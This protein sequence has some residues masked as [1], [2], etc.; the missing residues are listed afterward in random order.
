MNQPSKHFLSLLILFFNLARLSG[1]YTLADA[2]MA[3]VRKDYNQ[4]LKIC[5]FLK[6][7]GQQSPAIDTRFGIIFSSLSEHD[8][9]LYHLKLAEAGGEK[10]I[11]SGLLIAECYEALGK[12]DSASAKYEEVIYTDRTNLFPVISF[13]KMLITNRLYSDAVKWCQLLVDSVPDNFVFRKNL[14]GCFL[15]M[16]M[17]MEALYHLNEAW[18]LNNN[19]ISLLPA[20]TTG[21]LRAKIPESG[22]PVLREATA[23]HSDNPVVHKCS[24]NLYFASES[25]D[26]AAI[27]YKKAY[28]YGDTSLHIIRQLGLCYYAGN[29]FTEAVPF[30]LKSYESDTLDFEAVQY[31]ALSLSN[32]SRQKE[33]INYFRK[34]INILLPDSALLGSLH[35]EIG[36]ASGDINNYSVAI[37][38]YKEASKFLPDEIDY[39][40]ELARLYDA[41]KN[42]QEA[43]NHYERY[44]ANQDRL[45]KEIA[46][47]RNLNPAII[48]LGP[49]HTYARE[50]IEKMREELF[51]RGEIKRFNL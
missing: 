41:T 10:S 50:R 20:M 33:S 28:D 18:R 39:V 1:Q 26:S 15:Q 4:A 43:F 3:I 29:K 32:S 13:S 36:R 47:S 30:L 51:F 27:A 40:F 12:I 25:Y 5:D 31:L 14:G 49:R 45:I 24:G 38:S 34:S 11:S 2:D 9:A 6:N 7:L 21:W 23:L 19:D 44:L 46:E 48:N 22:L 17:D 16:S 8:K 35:A 37:N 42:Y